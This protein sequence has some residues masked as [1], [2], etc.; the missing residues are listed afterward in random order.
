[1]MKLNRKQKIKMQQMMPHKNKS[2]A[3][4]I[5]KSRLLEMER[6]KQEQERPKPSF[7]GYRIH[8]LP[9][10]PNNF[11]EDAIF[12]ANSMSRFYT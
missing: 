5:L 3:M 6:E 11:K 4:K 10:S 9:P 8:R 1:M 12:L 7:R 2:K